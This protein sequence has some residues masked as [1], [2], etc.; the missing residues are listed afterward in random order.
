LA[1]GHNNCTILRQHILLL[2][3]KFTLLLSWLLLGPV[4]FSQFSDS[5]HYHLNFASTGVINKTNDG[6]SY[7]FSN[8]LG[9]NTRTK[10]VAIN[11]SL[12][13]VYGTQNSDL[14]NNDFSA[15]GDIDLGKSVHRLY[16]WGLVNYDKSFSLKINYRLQAGAGIAYSFIDSPDLKIN[17]SDGILYEKGNITDVNKT[18]IVYEIPRNSIRLSYRWAIKDKFMITGI[19]FYQPSMKDISDYIIQSTSSVSVKLRKWLSI[20][21]AVIYN[22][23]SRT[24]RENLLITYGIAIERYF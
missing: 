9:F 3:R 13:W 19:H 15:H 11:T 6:K 8:G 22:K 18:D 24:K 17:I 10:K 12:A 21:S 5:I 7:V 4:C 1:Q 2:M 20:T 23:V 16:Y 14:T